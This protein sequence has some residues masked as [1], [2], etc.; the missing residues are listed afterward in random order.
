MSVEGVLWC[1]RTGGFVDTCPFGGGCEEEEGK[2]IL[3][4]ADFWKIDFLAVIMRMLTSARIPKTASFLST[5]FQ[6]SKKDMMRYLGPW[7]CHCA[8]SILKSSCYLN[9]HSSSNIFYCFHFV[10][11][12]LCWPFAFSSFPP[13]PPFYFL[14]GT[15]VVF[16]L[17]CFFFNN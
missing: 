14:F 9:Q 6:P 8:R 12:V 4:V 2:Q 3:K 1:R 10:F 16:V 15:H 17:Q 5:T 13:V 7:E 11:L